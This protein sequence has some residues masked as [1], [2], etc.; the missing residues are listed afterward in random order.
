MMGT[1]VSE[2]VEHIISTINHSG[3]SGSFFFSTHL[4][5]RLIVLAVDADCGRSYIA[6]NPE[7]IEKYREMLTRERRKPP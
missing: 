4:R 2:Y 3:E 5:E 7:T 6:V 1:E